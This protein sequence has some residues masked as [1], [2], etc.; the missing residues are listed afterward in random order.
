MSPSQ[1]QLQLHCNLSAE[2]NIHLIQIGSSSKRSVDDAEESNAAV[3]RFCKKKCIIHCT[4]DSSDLVNPKDEESWKTLLRA[5]EIRNHQEILEL[6]KSLS[7]GEVPFIYYHRKCRSIFTM[8]K[9]LDKLSQQSSNSQTQPEKVARRVSIRG[10][11][12]ISTTYERICIFCEKPKYFKGTRNREPLVQCRDMRADSSIRK[13]ATEKN[14]SKILALVSR[15]L[16]AAEACYHRTCYRSY[17]RPEASSIV[18]PDMSSESPDDEYARL[19]SDAYQMLFD[20]IRS[21]VIE[22][23]KVVRLSE[24]TQLLVQYLMSLEAKECKPSTKKHIKRNIE[25]EFNEL[26]KFENLLDNNRV[27]LIPASLTPVQIARNVLNILMAEK[28]DKG[29]TTKI[30]NIQKAAADIRDAIRNEE[31]KMSWPPRPS[32]L[33]DSAIEVPEELSAF[34]Y[35]LLTGNKDSSEGECCQ[36][37]QRLMKSFAQDLVFGVTRG[38]IKPPKQILLS[39]AVKTLTNNVELVSILNRYGHGISYSQLEEINTA[40]CMQKM[41]TTTSEIPLPANIQPHVSTTLA[42]DNIDRLEETLSGEGTSHRVNGIAVQARHFGPHPLTEQPPGITKSKQRSV[43]PL[44]VVALPI[45]NAGERQGPKPRAYVEV[46]DQ[47][48]LENARRKTLLWVLVRL[49]AQMN[50]KVSG[51]T[52]YNILVRN[53]IEARQ[54]NIGYLPTID[55]PAT[56]MSTVHEILVRS[57]KIREALELKSIVLVFDQALYAKATEIAWKHPDKFSDIVIRMG[58]FHTVCTLLSIIGKRFQDAGLRDV[59]IE[60]GVIAEGSVTGVL[61]GRRYNRAVRFHKLMY[62]ALQRLI[63]KGFQTWVEV[64]FPEKK[65]FIQDFF[66]GLKPLYDNLCQK[67][68][69]RVLDSQSFPEFITLYDMYLD[70]LR[71]NNGKLSSFWMS[72]IDLVDILLNM[73]AG[74]TKGFSL[75]AGAVSKYYIVSEFRSIFLKQ[76]RDM[77]NLSKSNSGHTDLQKTRIVRDEADVK[78]LI[79]MLESNWINPFSAEQQDLVCLST[80]KVA[81]QKIE[82]DLLGAKSV[83]EKAYK[84]FR[85]Q[86]LEANPPVKFHE[87]LK[88]SKL[89]TFSDLNKKVKFKSKTANEII[90]KADRALFGQ[91]VIIAENRQL[92]MRDVLCHPLG[93]LPWALSTV[94]GS[95]RKTSKAAL[96][97]ELQKN[98]PAAEEIP[99]PSACIIDGMVLVQRLKGD[100]KKFSDVADSLF[101]MVLHEGASSKR[102]DVIFDVYRENSIKNTEREHRGA[103]YGNEFRNLQPDHKVQQW[104]KFLLNPQNKKA[105]TIFVTKEWQQD[106]YRRKL[107]DK[108]LFV[109]CEEECHQISPEAAF[110]VEELS[111]TQEEADTRILLHLSHAARSD[112]NT[113]IVASEDTDVFI[114]SLGQNLCSSLLG[115]H[116]YTGCDTVS[117]FAGR[118]KIG[119]LRIVKEQRSFQEMFDLLGVEWELSDD[120]FQMLQNFTCRMYSSRPGTNSINEL[121][122]RLFCSKRGNIESDQLPPC[123]DCLYKH[124]CRANYQTGIWRRSLENCPEI[125]SPLRHGWIQDENKLGIDWMSGQ[126]APATVL[127]LLSCSCTRSCRLPNCSCLANGL[128]CTDMC[129]LSECDNRREEQAVTVDV[130]ADDDESDED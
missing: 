89:K 33:N 126:P 32:E 29:S 96:A 75:K 44:D 61:E 112:Y 120:L 111:S 102:I 98:V 85:A 93:P 52:G 43:E 39:Y 76:L 68:Q 13:I 9:L 87:T 55:A 15:E 34:L 53:E 2:K 72:Y 86:R 127:E 110:T 118:G 69:Q 74:G 35:T 73:T 121:R 77:L 47:E 71:N 105:L 66:A 18:N 54:D 129:R 7:E 128:K 109:A 11:S 28:E 106:K 24:M 97:K 119:A 50:Q 59:C 37:V 45:Y 49:H 48:A 104:R 27:F 92:H 60:S 41:A 3:K 21:D 23:E 5:A 103:E 114:L 4:D 67:E 51:W 8:K 58:V 130:D 122:Y 30:S 90:L 1:L 99:Q 94:D 108:V 70:Y 65:Q 40:L 64:K 36:R 12:N 80:G 26:I 115:M 22:K 57:Q 79:A 10:S 124:A 17:T 6:S 38:R 113:L 78:S 116:A 63:W 20:F 107:T 88:K 84:E 82:E 91:M 95:L 101:G 117:A 25:A 125:P 100:H 16:V 19:E 123:A 31:S 42:W 81:T 14:D 62:E 56:S 46:N 83:G